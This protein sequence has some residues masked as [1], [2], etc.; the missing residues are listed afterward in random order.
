MVERME[1]NDLDGALA[2]KAQGVEML[3]KVIDDDPSNIAAGLYIKAL[4][5]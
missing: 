4:Q 5:V 3:R 2:I 1:V